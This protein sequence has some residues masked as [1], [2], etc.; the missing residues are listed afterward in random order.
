M[1]RWEP[2]YKKAILLIA[3]L[4]VIAYALSFAVFVQ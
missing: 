2:N 4:T 1:N 3:V